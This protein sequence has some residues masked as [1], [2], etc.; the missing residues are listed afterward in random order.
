[1]G[2]FQDLN[3][4]MLSNLHEPSSSSKYT[5][6][7]GTFQVL[8]E[9]MLNEY[10]PRLRALMLDLLNRYYQGI[11]SHKVAQASDLFGTEVIALDTVELW[12]GVEKQGGLDPALP[13]RGEVPA[14]KRLTIGGAFAYFA[15]LFPD[16]S[17]LFDSKHIGVSKYAGYNREYLCGGCTVTMVQQ[18]KNPVGSKENIINLIDTPICSSLGCE[19][20]KVS[21]AWWSMSHK[22]LVGDDV[23]VEVLN[24]WGGIDNIYNGFFILDLNPLLVD[25]GTDECVASSARGLWDV[26]LKA[27]E[28]L[29][30]KV[31]IRVIDDQAYKDKTAV[32][33]RGSISASLSR[34]PSALPSGQ[35]PATV[36]RTG[37]VLFG[38]AIMAVALGLVVATLRIRAK[39]A[40]APRPAA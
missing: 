31:M 36:S 38:V 25:S 8:N 15:L 11:G 13:E 4:I 37:G 26:R 20:G 14:K 33:V 5:P 17:E 29:A 32:A 23:A 28:D 39:V 19:H 34:A 30:A 2:T 18:K 9:I 1:M 3:E 22:L 12:G 7:T 10:A 24:G 21:C 35:P 27:L 40:E 16:T 6:G